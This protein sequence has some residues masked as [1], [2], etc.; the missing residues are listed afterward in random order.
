ML[1]YRHAFHAGNFADLIKHVVLVEILEHL[2]RKATPFEYIDT[3][4]GAGLY[5]LHSAA[6]L[7]LREYAGG[8]GRLQPQDYPEMARYFEVIQAFNAADELAFYPGSPAI[9]GYFLRPQDRAWLFE[10][11][12]RD[13]ELLRANLAGN[14]RMKVQCQDGFEGL[15]ALL[16]PTSR[17]GLVLI[18]PSYEVKSDYD[19]VVDRLLAACR[20]FSHGI[21]ALWYPVVE[22]RRIDELETRIA[23]SGI[24]NVQ[25]FEL[26]VA[27]DSAARGMTAAG[28]LVVNPPWKLLEK[29][30][31]LL[32]KLAPALAEEGGGSYKCEVLAGE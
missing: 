3:H 18:D 25:R 31:G 2:V 15:Q 14:R 21:Y 27:P 22:R 8:I 6:A 5:D 19:L 20:K 1:S 16:P 32:P 24:R 30:A 17:R 26:G 23:G 7:K 29:M 13:Y 11:H 4:A 28:M 12:P 10:L 9:A